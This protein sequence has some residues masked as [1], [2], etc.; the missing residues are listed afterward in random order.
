[1][2]ETFLTQLVISNVELCQLGSTIGNLSKT[3]GSDVKV[4]TV[5]RSQSWEKLG[6]Q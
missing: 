2:L 3:T 4:D 1:M 5:E 6:Q